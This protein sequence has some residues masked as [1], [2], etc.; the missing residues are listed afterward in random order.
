MQPLLSVLLSLLVLGGIPLS[1]FAQKSEKNDTVVKQKTLPFKTKVKYADALFNAGNYY[2]AIEVYKEALNEKPDN[3]YC[4]Y[5][6]GESFYKARDYAT[7]EKWFGKLIESGADGNYPLS[8]FRYAMMLKMNAKYDEA[9][10]AFAKFALRADGDNLTRAKREIEACEFAR[11]N[12]EKPTDFRVAHLGDS[13]NTPYAEYAP[14]VREDKLYY[15][16]LNRD[17][18]LNPEFPLSHI[19]VSE[20]NSNNWQKGKLVKGEVNSSQIHSGNPAFSADGKRMYFTQC[21][22]NGE[23]NIRCEILLSH[24][25]NG[26]WGQPILLGREVNDGKFNN[27]HPAPAFGDSTTDILYFSSNRTGGIGGFDIW[28]SEVKFDGTAKPAVNLGNVINTIDDEVTPFYFKNKLHFSSNGHIG[29][30]GLD[31]FSSSGMKSGWTK[32]QNLGFPLNSSVDDFYFTRGELPKIYY[33]VSNRPGIIGLKS[34]TCCDDIFVAEDLSVPVLSFRGRVYEKGESDP[35][36]LTGA[37]VEVFEFKG[38]NKT[39][40]YDELLVGDFKFSYDLTAGKFYE[41][42]I[43]KKA[44]FPEIFKV[45]TKDL[46]ESEIMNREIA[47]M[48]IEKNRT[49]RLENVYYEF[50]KTNLTEESKVVLRRLFDLLMENPKLVVEISSHTDNVGKA[51]YN[52]K[53]SQQRAESCVKYL[54]SLGIEGK[55]LIPKGYGQTVP[56]APNLKPDGTDNPDGR[57]LNRRTEF[58]VVGELSR[59]G[60]MIIFD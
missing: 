44:Y 21:T 57:K 45:S 15:A 3:H 28:Y 35:V 38:E 55:R 18:S 33:F 59:V 60:D 27:T 11:V 52:Q 23:A 19:F 51:D 39:T 40:L 6:L 14:A 12:I 17:T 26:F 4:V 31:I 10:Y 36:L 13:L 1:V 56:V 50:D 43:Q 16:S 7:A 32:P 5:Q 20:K 53:L 9:K 30:G 49:Y 34:A 47:L 41:F 22:D 42:K 46:L 29:F 54:V 24:F 48:K 25:E 2:D 58:M 8:Y 37:R